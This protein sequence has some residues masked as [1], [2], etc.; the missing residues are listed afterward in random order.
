MTI[1]N[2]LP[3]RYFT[4]EEGIGGVV[5]DRPGDFIVE[6]LPL[7]EPSGSGE[8]LYLRLEKSATSHSELISVVRRHFGVTDRE[9]G[10]AG[11]KDKH[12]V[13]RQTVSVHLL[14]DPADLELGH[15][16]IRVIWAARHR[17]KLR[18]GHLAG[19]RFSIR[20]R[21]VDPARVTG[22]RRMLARIGATGFPN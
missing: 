11:M 16:R 9:I 10:F 6:E 17:N 21:E 19:N 15:D 5:K 22:V 4:D 12:A 8:H 3:R 14:E 18:L 2:P 7:Y 20:I 1:D 13:T